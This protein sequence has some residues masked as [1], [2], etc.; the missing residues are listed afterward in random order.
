MPCERGVGGA[1]TEGFDDLGGIGATE[2]ECAVGRGGEF[3]LLVEVVVEGILDD[4][5]SVVV[6]G[7]QV[8][9]FAGVLVLEG[10]VVV[11]EVGEFPDLFALATQSQSSAKELTATD[12][13]A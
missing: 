1:V 2:G 7:W 9:A 12:G 13:V 11:A 8:E 6:V 3:P 4:L 10:V 5:G